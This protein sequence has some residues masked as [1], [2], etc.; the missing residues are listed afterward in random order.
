MLA[1]SLD[2]VARRI[3]R[4]GHHLALFSEV[5]NAV[6]I[7]EAYIRAVYRESAPADQFLGLNLPE[8]TEAVRAGKFEWAPDGDEAFDDGSY[9][10]Q[11]DVGDHVR[12]IA[13]RQNEE[14][15]DIIVDLGQAWLASSDFYDVLEQW[16]A[17]FLSEWQALLKK[18]S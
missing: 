2:E 18:P 15:G 13:F 17:C 5:G 6:E 14:D 8:F 11:F 9:V 4:R 16:R 10:L 12:L 1:C 7:A 3:A